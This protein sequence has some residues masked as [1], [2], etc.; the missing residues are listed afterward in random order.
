MLLLVGVLILMLSLA[1]IIYF[2]QIYYKF[3]KAKIILLKQDL[4]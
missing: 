4:A 3:A 1:G 2:G